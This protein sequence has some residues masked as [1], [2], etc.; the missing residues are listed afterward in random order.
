MFH[1]GG[2]HQSHDDCIPTLPRAPITHLRRGFV[3]DVA[4]LP[5]PEEEEYSI[6]GK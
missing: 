1:C 6:M 2:S 5:M 3:L 4:A